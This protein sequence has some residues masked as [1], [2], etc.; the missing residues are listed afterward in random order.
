MGR[1]IKLSPGRSCVYI[2]RAQ[3]VKQRRLKGETL[4]VADDIV[5]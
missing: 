1:T 2:E 4:L 3:K 5:W